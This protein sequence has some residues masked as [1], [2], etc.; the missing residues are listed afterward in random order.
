MNASDLINII[1][2]A[3]NDVQLDDG[4]SI[5]QARLL[6]DYI[7]DVQSLAL[8]RDIDKEKSW[9]EVKDTKIEELS[10]GLPFLDA[11]GFR[12]YL[13]A[14]MSY[15][16]RNPCSEFLA[17]DSAI[18]NSYDDNLDRFHIFNPAQ[19]N[20]IKVFLQFCIESKYYDTSTASEAI[21]KW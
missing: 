16:L 21:K 7:N 5:T 9:E 14:F 19:K 13:P 18:Y 12:Y 6:D 4:T 15:A 8:A 2:D 20:A 10:D 11:K 17:V 3:F 1:S